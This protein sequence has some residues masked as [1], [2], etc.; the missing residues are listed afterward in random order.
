[1]ET[2]LEARLGQG[3]NLRCIID[4]QSLVQT[5]LANQLENVVS[6]F[7]VESGIFEEGFVTFALSHDVSLRFDFLLNI[8]DLLSEGLHLV[9]GQI[10]D[11]LD[12]KLL[13]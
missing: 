13:F 5:A 12:R 10:R 2:L 7:V 3:L 6:V 11:V 9:R 4:S 1:M 8:E